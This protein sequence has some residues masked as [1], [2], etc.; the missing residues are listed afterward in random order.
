MCT[1]ADAGILVSRSEQGLQFTDAVAVTF[2]A[3][4]K[5]LSLGDQTKLSGPISKLPSTHLEGVLLKDSD[6]GILAHFEEG[7]A[8]YLLPQGLPKTAPDNPAA[9]WKTAKITY[10][11]SA[12]DKAGTDIAAAAFVAF[13][14]AG[15][16][17]L[18]RLCMDDAALQLIG[19]K[20]KSFPAQIELMSAVVKA[21]G[22]N[23]AMAPLGKFVE[24]AMRRRYDQFESGAAGVDVLTQGLKFVELSQ[25]VYPEQSGA[26]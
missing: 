3:K 24:D 7:K 5:A 9:I 17:E 14:P 25:A 6:A 15:A 1:A 19:G 21:Y 8:E 26:G 11:K 20:G 18:T 4:D 13:L 12:Q 10:K 16:E 22:S 23:P 2:N